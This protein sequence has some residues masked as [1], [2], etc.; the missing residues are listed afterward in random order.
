VYR[1]ELFRQYGWLIWD[2][3]WYGGHYLLS[4]SVLFPPIGAMLGLN[5]AAALSAGGAAWA[6]DRLL[7]ASWPSVGILPGVVF[8]AGTVVPVVIGQYPFLCGEAAGLLAVYATR[9][10]RWALATVL[11]LCCALFSPVAGTFLVVA[12]IALTFGSS[13]KDRWILATTAAVA[14]VPIAALN[15]AFYDSGTFPFWGS[16]LVVVLAL[17]VTGVLV[18]P[19]KGT[20][21]LRFALVLYSA[22]ALFLFL[23]P[24]ALGG[25]FV[26]LASA[27]GPSL[28]IAAG[29]L[30][31]RRLLALGVVP[32]LFWQMA[33]AWAAIRTAS[34]DGSSNP[35]YYQPL[36]R[37]ITAKRPTGRVE[38]P[39]T[40]THWE[41]AFVA[42]HLSIARGWERQTDQASNP[43][44]YSGRALTPSTY[45]RWLEDMGVEWVALPDVPLDYSARGEAALLR[46]PPSYLRLVWSNTHWKLWRVLGSPGIVDNGARLV[47]L[48]PSEISLT[49]T[50]PGPVTVRVHYTSTWTVAT[51]RACVGRAADGWTRLD[52]ASPGPVKLV[53]TLFGDDDSDCGP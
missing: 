43:I 12:L 3:R 39:F 28:A 15:V 33:P 44:F 42:S 2:S 6:F 46:N 19:R 52:V 13:G 36:V 17:C 24:N 48:T 7:R 37:F 50:Q 16:D 35:A 9:T 20:R 10:R 18:V 32:L 47:S 53:A 30:P 26:R 41:A 29:R 4:Y 5:G 23:W 40:L 34:G 14:A 8:A 51:G 21:T 27:V 49:A 1:V 25:N 11:S 31:S 22:A 45:Q 38:I